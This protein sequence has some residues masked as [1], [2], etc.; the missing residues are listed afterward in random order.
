M[1]KIKFTESQEELIKLAIDDYCKE[2]YTTKCRNQ[3]KLLTWK[4]ECRN[5][6]NLSQFV[7]KIG[8]ELSEIHDLFYEFGSLRNLEHYY[9][10]DPFIHKISILK[11][12]MER[13]LPELEEKLNNLDD[14][15]DIS[16]YLTQINECENIT[17]TLYDFII[18]E[19]DDLE[20][21]EFVPEDNYKEYMLELRKKHRTL[22]EKIKQKHNAVEEIAK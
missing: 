3:M 16:L 20:R 9:A 22:K 14:Q 19:F 18:Y 17:S 1:K 11:S 15:V 13:F 12:S 5:E 7:D 8:F 21:K 2:L 4:K 10:E 6:E